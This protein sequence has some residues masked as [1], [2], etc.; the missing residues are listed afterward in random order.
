MA[1]QA[2]EPLIP[3][4]NGDVARYRDWKRS[5]LL[6]HAGTKDDQRVLTG[7]RVLGRLRGGAR[8]ATRHLDP[9][10]IRQQGEEGLRLLLQKLDSAYDWQPESLLYESLE[11]FL[12][13]PARKGGESV[14]SYLAKY[15]TALAQFE[16]TINEHREK[17]TQ[18]G[19]PKTCAR[20]T[21]GTIGLAH[22]SHR[23][24]DACHAKR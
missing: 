15:H 9:E 8:L 6:Y 21:A 4:F 3:E 18:K 16:R 1:N 14:T 20:T 5:V 19:L 13:F 2:N 11:T 10:E 17:E 22:R 24:D 23:R 7:A 12:Y